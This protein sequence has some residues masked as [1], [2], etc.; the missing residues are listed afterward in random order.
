M[1][2]TARPTTSLVNST[3]A[4]MNSTIEPTQLNTKQT[5]VAH[6]NL[7]STTRSKAGK[8]FITEGTLALVLM[9][10]FIGLE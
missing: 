1:T 6:T 10:R 9:L 7:D 2:T 5:T 8:I 4:M 3:Q